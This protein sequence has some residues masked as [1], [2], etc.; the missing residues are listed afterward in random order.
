MRNK[1]CRRKGA[2]EF[3]FKKQSASRIISNNKKSYK[4]SKL[5]FG[6]KGSNKRA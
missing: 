5:E 6:S 1:T 2:K 4:G 3:N